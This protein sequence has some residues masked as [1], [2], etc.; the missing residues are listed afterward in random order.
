MIRTYTPADRD[1]LTDLFARAGADS[2]TGELWRHAPSEQMV[3]L[4][5]YVE[6]CPDT[7]FLAEAG[8]DLLQTVTMLAQCGGSI[9]GSARALFVHANTVRYRLRR[10][11]DVT[12]RNPTDPHDALTLQ[13]ALMLGRLQDAGTLL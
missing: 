9:E 2:P 10:V 8:G 6:H 11:A 5:A 12:G 3:Y 1:A 7:L 13:V 4:D